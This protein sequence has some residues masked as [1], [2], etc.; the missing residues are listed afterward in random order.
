MGNATAREHQAL[1]TEDVEDV[2]EGDVD[3]QDEAYQEETEEQWRARREGRASNK[4]DQIKRMLAV[5]FFAGLGIIVIIVAITSAP[6]LTPN[7][8][9]IANGTTKMMPQNGDM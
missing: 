2:D 6:L 3:D 8:E 9:D 1:R 7:D 4:L 5:A